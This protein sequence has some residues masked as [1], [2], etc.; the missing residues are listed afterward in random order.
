[1][2]KLVH[3]EGSNNVSNVIFQAIR[4]QLPSEISDELIKIVAEE[5]SDRIQVIRMEE[6]ELLSNL[7]AIVDDED[8][9][10][11]IHLFQMCD[12]G[13]SWIFDRNTGELHTT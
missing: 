9:E 3:I 2:N 11:D 5:C 4:E 13:I 7:I 1:M 8:W 12:F 6:S 10:G